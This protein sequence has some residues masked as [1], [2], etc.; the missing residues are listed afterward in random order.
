[1]KLPVKIFFFIYKW[2]LEYSGKYNDPSGLIDVVASFRR[3]RTKDVWFHFIWNPEI[4]ISSSIFTAGSSDKSVEVFK[5]PEHRRQ[6][7]SSLNCA[8]YFPPHL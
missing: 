3:T 4:M 5:L 1:M 2:Y 6:N 7:A 8:S